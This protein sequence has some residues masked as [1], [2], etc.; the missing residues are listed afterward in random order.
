MVTLVLI[1]HANAKG[2]IAEISSRKQTGIL[3]ICSLTIGFISRCGDG[4]VNG[5]E[6]CEES[7]DCGAS[8]VCIGCQ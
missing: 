7:S 6:A 1:K 4:T 8:E 2:K 3:R 5:F